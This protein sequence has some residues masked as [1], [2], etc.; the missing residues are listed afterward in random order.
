[1][2]IE[3]VEITSDQ[4]NQILVAE[5]SH[6]LDLKSIDI[7]PGKLCKFISG[8][9]N[10]DGGE[11]FIGIDEDTVV[12]KKTRAWRGFTDRYSNKNIF[13]RLRKKGLIKIV[14][15]KSRINAKWCK[16]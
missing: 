10:A 4:L 3:V 13:Y 12:G 5:E 15:G 9:A 14:P 6:F 16:V 8:F 11:L 7:Q 1:M 2:S